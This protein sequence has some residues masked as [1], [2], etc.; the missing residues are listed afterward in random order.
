MYA[1]VEGENKRLVKALA[2][3]ETILSRVMSER[4]RGK[5][6][7]TTI[8]EENRALSQGRELDAEKI[9]NLTAAVGASKKMAAEAT[10]ASNK[11]QE[12]NRSLSA[13]ME[14]R[15]RI[16]DDTAVKLRGARAENEETKRERDAYQGR[17]EQAA[18]EYKEDKF[19]ARRLREKLSEVEGLLKEAEET[20]ERRKLEDGRSSE[21]ER[22][23]DE[24]M[25]DYRRKLNCSVVTS[26]AKEV[27][28]VR[29]G[30]M[31]SRQCID[32]LVQTRNRKCPLCGKPFGNDDV[33][34]IF[35]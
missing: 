29:C 26:Q 11:A 5:Q 24:I 2:E 10:A 30:H 8:K 1:E 18:V 22:V 4:L 7:L 32:N 19:E 27:V 28:L 25:R 16:A 13:E 20:V 33:R 35:F 9:K 21:D 14:K 34:N 23:R 31:F 12:E 15:Q 3:K 6:M 17:A